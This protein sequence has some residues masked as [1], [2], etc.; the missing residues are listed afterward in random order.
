MTETEA[1]KKRCPCNRNTR[2]SKN[3]RQSRRLKQLEDQ[4][5]ELKCKNAKANDNGKSL[6]A[7]P[8]VKFEDLNRPLPNTEQDDRGHTHTHPAQLK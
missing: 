5:E 3:Q 1:F 2:S 4:V 7:R 6:T 8:T